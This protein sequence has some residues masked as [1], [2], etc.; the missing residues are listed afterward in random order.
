MTVTSGSRTAP[1]RS[2]AALNGNKTDQDIDQTQGGSY[3]LGSRDGCKCASGSDYLQVA[4]QESKSAQWADADA[5]ALQ[6]GASNEN[7]PVRVGSKGDDGDVWQSNSTTAVAAA[8][9]GNKTDQDIDQTQ[10]GSYG[11]GSRDGCKCASGSDYLQVAGQ[12]S[13]S[14]QWAD[15][16]AIALQKGA[17][18]EN[19]PVAVLS[20]GHGK[21]H[22]KGSDRC[23]DRCSDKGDGGNVWQSNSTTAV[24]AALNGNKTEQS[25]HQAQPGGFG[26]L[27]LQAAGQRNTSGQ[28]KRRR[29]G[30]TVRGL[31][32]EHPGACR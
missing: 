18:N 27:Y 21:G 25:I 16:D 12:E 14:A 5:I 17:S 3:G 30:S 9:N 22:G 10:G 15:A 29:T 11:L 4:G 20:G 2:A 26:P 7:T 6:K 13:K 24:A 8:L 31:E 23:S 19:T 32:R 28:G 1:R